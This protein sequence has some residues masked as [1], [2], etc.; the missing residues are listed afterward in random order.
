M[1]REPL[2]VYQC[3]VVVDFNLQK[4]IFRIQSKTNIYDGAICENR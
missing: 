1:G 2:I 4:P 3:T